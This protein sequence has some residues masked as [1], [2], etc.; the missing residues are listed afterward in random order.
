MGRTI[1]GSNPGSGK[2]FF[3]S[4]KHPKG[5]YSRASLL[6]NGFQGSFPGLKQLGHIV[7]HHHHLVPSLR[8][9][10]AIPLF[11][12]YVFMMWKLKPLPFIT[13]KRLHNETENLKSDPH[14]EISK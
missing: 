7:D 10:G 12:P 9:S 14:Y 1:W 2:R 5:L 3:S 13:F 11:P 6:F 4:P 8:M